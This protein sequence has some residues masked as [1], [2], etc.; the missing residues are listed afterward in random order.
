MRGA[1]LYTL[2]DMKNK[3]VDP[4]QDIYDAWTTKP[5]AVANTAYN[6]MVSALVDLGSWATADIFQFFSTHT[7]DNGEA[8]KNWIS[9]GTLDPSMEETP[10]WSQYNGFLSLVGLPK[11]YIK[12]NYTPSINAVK[13]QLNA[14][15]LIIGNGTNTND[16]SQFGC[17]DAG[18]I[19]AKIASYDGGNMR[20][21]LNS[22][23]NDTTPN[24]IGGGIGYFG[25]TRPDDSNVKMWQN[26]TST[27]KVKSTDSLPTRELFAGAYNIGSA[28][29]SVNRLRFV[30]AGG[31]LTD[32]QYIG[33]INAIETCLDTL[34]TGL[35]P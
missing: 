4:Y 10:D 11:A 5:S 26:L 12:T 31:Y 14:A 34:G 9:P 30:W 20:L 35:I 19:E 18:S 23:F 13:Y 25:G 2:F 28:E 15:T 33:T 1:H 27:S 21:S 32:A 22:Q 24:T 16:G 17:N 6:K 7:N 29:M 3:N 8:L